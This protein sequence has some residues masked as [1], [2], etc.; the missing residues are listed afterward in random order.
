V[1]WKG[2]CRHAGFVGPQ[3]RRAQPVGRR[4]PADD[5][6]H[7]LPRLRIVR[8]TREQLAQLDGSRELAALLLIFDVSKMFAISV[9]KR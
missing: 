4:P 9:E 2:E 1:G 7:A 3:S 6:A 8:N 5:R